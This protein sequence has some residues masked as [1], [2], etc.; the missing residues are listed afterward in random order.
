MADE[1]LRR[2]K[3][4]TKLREKVIFLIEH[5]MESW[6]PDKRLIRRRLGK[7][8]TETVQELLSLQDAD[9]GSKGV[10]TDT[11]NLPQ[12]HELLQEVLAE[13]ACFS[14]KDLA[15]NGKDLLNAGFPSCPG[16]GNLLSYLLQQVQDEIIPNEKSPLLKEAQQVRN[17]FF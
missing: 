2:L 9:F 5:H 7:Y 10:C 11:T 13:D 1:A 4:P 16:L 8:G 14:L 6:E 17:R 15:V 3:A 12:I